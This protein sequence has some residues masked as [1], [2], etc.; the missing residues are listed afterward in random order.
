[1][2]LYH[3][4]H[5][6]DMRFQI[7][8]QQYVVPP[9]GNVQ[10]PRHLDYVVKSSGLLLKPGPSPKGSTAPAAIVAQLPAQR[11]G[12]TDANV[13]RRGP[14]H[15]TDDDGQG[16]SDL[17]GLASDGSLANAVDDTQLDRGGDDAPEAGAAVVDSTVSQ[18]RAAGVRL[19]AP[20]RR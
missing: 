15:E 4:P 18:L 5:G 1:M 13:A 11:P 12:I 3:N 17:E 20:K 2:G 10:I 14:Q 9:E 6:V 7:A 8:G 19:P 16:D